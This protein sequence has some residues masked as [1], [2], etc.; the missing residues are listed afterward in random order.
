VRVRARGL[1]K[2]HGNGAR[3]AGPVEFVVG[4]GDRVLGVRA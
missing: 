4:G 2:A 1:G 3:A